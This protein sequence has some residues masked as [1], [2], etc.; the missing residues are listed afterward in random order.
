MSLLGG[1][2]GTAVLCGSSSVVDKRSCPE[3][4]DTGTGTMWQ[5]GALVP[6]YAAAGHQ[7]TRRSVKV[8]RNW[9]L[10]ELTLRVA[11]CGLAAPRGRGLTR[12]S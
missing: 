10:L 9:T 4:S 12:R 7:A 1:L 3:K 8:P 5:S 6:R 11:L 2:T